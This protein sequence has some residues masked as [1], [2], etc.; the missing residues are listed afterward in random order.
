MK[1]SH[2]SHSSHHNASSLSHTTRNSSHSTSQTRSTK[3][4]WPQPQYP[5]GSPN[6]AAQMGFPLRLSNG[7][8]LYTSQIQNSVDQRSTMTHSEPRS[9]IKFPPK[10]PW[11]QAKYPLGSPNRY[12]QMGTPTKFDSSQYLLDSRTFEPIQNSVNRSRSQNSKSRAYSYEEEEYYEEP[13]NSRVST[14]QFEPPQPHK[15]S[16]LN[17]PDQKRLN[18][19][20]SKILNTQLDEETD[21]VFGSDQIA[22]PTRYNHNK[23]VDLGLDSDQNPDL[24]Q[25]KPKVVRQRS[26]PSERKHSSRHHSSHRRSKPKDI[27]TES[28]AS[29]VAAD[30]QNRLSV[31][32]DHLDYCIGV[33]QNVFQPIEEDYQNYSQN[34]SPQLRSRMPKSRAIELAQ[35]EKLKKAAQR[36]L[37]DKSDLDENEEEEIKPKPQKP[38]PKASRQTSQSKK[39]QS[40]AQKPEE[41]QIPKETF[42]KQPNQ[43]PKQPIQEEIKQEK[44]KQPQYAVENVEEEDINEEELPESLSDEELHQIEDVVDAGGKNNLKDDI[45]ESDFD[46]PIPPPTPTDPIGSPAIKNPSPRIRNSPN[47]SFHDS[48]SDSDLLPLFVPPVA[49]EFEPQPISV[50]LARAK[51]ES[52]E[53]DIDVDEIMRKVNNSEFENDKLPKTANLSSL[54]L[55]GLNSFKVDDDDDILMHGN[56][57]LSEQQPSSGHASPFPKTK[58]F[59]FHQNTEISANLEEEEEEEDDDEF[60]QLLSQKRDAGL[61]SPVAEEESEPEI[62]FSPIKTPP[63]SDE[64][65]IKRLEKKVE[66]VIEEEDEENPPEN[67]NENNNFQE[68]DENDEDDEDFK[69]LKDDDQE[70]NQEVDNEGWGQ[71]EEE[72]QPFTE[73][74]NQK[75]KQI[76]SFSD[77]DDEKPKEEAVIE[78]PNEDPIDSQKEE[79]PSTTE[80]ETKPEPVVEQKEEVPPTTE[81]I[82]EQI[83]QKEEVPS[84]METEKVTENIETP[85]PIEEKKEEVPSTIEPEKVPE[86]DE[87]TPK[88]RDVKLDQEIPVE[89][90]STP[91]DNKV[92]EN[93]I[94]VGDS[95][96]FTAPPDEEED[97]NLV[98]DLDDLLGKVGVG[99]NEGIPS[100]DDI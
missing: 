63:I 53:S 12:S 21:S 95:I 82:E 85:E 58:M 9:Q 37:N 3:K 50:L 76:M 93:S 40:P 64:S 75:I 65:L 83:P 32:K 7:S 35:D 17:N 97:E 74:L 39:Q 62:G 94:N 29:E 86:N 81:K 54:N 19:K 43:P 61:K 34:L 78:T 69:N 38:A 72:D 2:K 70:K 44:P 88:E 68:N 49:D 89:Q 36:V 14:K 73:E 67:E 80:N 11:P 26:V 31:I 10:G 13:Q 71:P 57:S 90:V 1:H 56:I 16:Y 100:D 42:Q 87:T 77:A 30:I 92:G 46:S 51:L 24:P 28:E 4:P 47:K 96:V 60:A 22:P 15:Y 25:E 5:I 48:D 91:D 84:T 8:P 23:Y 59:S 55:I 79:V 98:D 33:S 6:R 18:N 52:D 20:I 41:R 27:I 45:N 99:A 66:E